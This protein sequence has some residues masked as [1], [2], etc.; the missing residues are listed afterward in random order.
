MLTLGIA[1]AFMGLTVAS[2]TASEMRQQEC[3]GFFDGAKTRSG[4][5]ESPGYP[6]QYPVG[7]SCQWRITAPKGQKV[8]LKIIDFDIANSKDCSSDSLLVSDSGDETLQDAVKLCGSSAPENITSLEEALVLNFTSNQ[9]D[10]CRGFKAEFRVLEEILT[11]GDSS[12]SLDFYITSPNYPETAPEEKSE[13]EVNIE[14]DCEVEICQVRLDFEEFQIQPPVWGDCQ[15]DQFYVTGNGGKLPTLCGVNNGSHMYLSVEGRSKTTLTFMLDQL[16]RSF[17]NCWDTYHV[18]GTEGS[19]A[20]PVGIAR[21]AERFM[22]TQPQMAYPVNVTVALANY[23]P[24]KRTTFPERRAWKIH[25]NQIPCD[26]VETKVPRAPSGCLQYY[27]GISGHIKGFNFDGF[28]CFAQVPYCKVHE[29][30]DPSD[31]D[32]RV[33]FTG[34]LNNLDYSVCIQEEAGFCGIEYAESQPNSFSMTNVTE[35]PQRT[36]P[37]AQSGDRLCASDYLGIVRSRSAMPEKGVPV[38]DDRFCGTALG[39]T[40]CNGP[41][42]SYSKPFIVR[43]LSDGDEYSE[44]PDYMNRGFHLDYTQIPCQP[45]TG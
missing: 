10:S 22:P 17:Y 19:N 25:V 3:G 21:N 23:I 33:G 6:H 43:V 42:R 39:L 30:V 20:P 32:M 29:M 9:H 45:P 15:Y 36:V 8:L 38:T 31:C 41:I 27:E 18:F 35:L 2:K 40:D 34:H 1:V 12:P 37:Y 24:A 28:G 14:H 5:I 4:I 13:C 26:C 11:C 16:Q 44:S 7:I